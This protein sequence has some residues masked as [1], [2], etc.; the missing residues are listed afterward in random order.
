MQCACARIK[1]SLIDEW[2]SQMIA[3]G[4]SAAIITEAHGVLKRVLDRAVRDKVIPA[5]PCAE[6][7]M[8]L[9]RRQQVER[10]VLSP[11]EVEK[12]AQACPHERDKVLIR[13]LAYAGVRIGEALGLQWPAVD[14]EKRVG[15]EN[16][17]APHATCTYSSTRPPSQSVGFWPD[18]RCGGWSAAGGR[19]LLELLS[20]SRIKN[21]NCPPGRRGPS[22][23]CGPAG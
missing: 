8:K 9:P 21:R 4:K 6:R 12:I 11:A 2:V 5:N 3:D 14:L 10:P 23:G 16:P 1:P 13:F 17:V 15:A 20:R 22:A 7:G 19:P 18:G